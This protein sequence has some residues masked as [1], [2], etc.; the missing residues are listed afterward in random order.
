M[1]SILNRQSFNGVDL[2]CPGSGLDILM[3]KCNAGGVVMDEVTGRLLAFDAGRRLLLPV[4]GQTFWSASAPRLITDHFASSVINSSYSLA[5][6]SNGSTAHF[7]A[8]SGTPSVVKGTTGAAGTGVA[9]DAV[10]ISGPLSFKISDLTR[11]MRFST[12]IK[13]SAIT[14]VMVFVGF[15]DTLPTT[16]L[17]LPIEL[18]AGSTTTNA[19]DAVGLV[20]DTS[21]T[22]D[23]W[24]AVAVNN[25]TDGTT[26]DSGTAPV[27]D[28]YQDITVEL[29]T[30]GNAKVW[31]NT[32][33]VATLTAAVRTSVNL[34]PI[35]AA[36]ARSTST[37]DITLDLFAAC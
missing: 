9:A 18:S 2:S 20:F 12:R 5:K 21:A 11:P 6:G 17:E 16:T 36:C 8:V 19:T 10:T 35:V 7:A 31:L 30:S 37:R 28:T 13:L 15:T 26:T 27:A 4:D 33:L 32:T 25:D 34:C 1:P 29:D 24:K 23:N 3:E 14:N 22:L